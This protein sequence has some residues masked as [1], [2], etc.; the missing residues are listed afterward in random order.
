MTQPLASLA[1]G[2]EKFITRLGAGFRGA[3]RQ[4]SQNWAQHGASPKLF[5]GVGTRAARGARVAGNF[6][7]P[8]NSVVKNLAQQAHAERSAF[9]ASQQARPPAPVAG[10]NL[11]PYALGAGTLVGGSYLLNKGTDTI[12]QY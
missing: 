12:S 8:Q 2:G 6:Y 10:K 4:L 11:L 9:A 7:T 1:T 5:S 3:G